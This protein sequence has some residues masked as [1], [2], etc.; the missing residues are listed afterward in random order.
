MRINIPGM[1]MI[2]IDEIIERAPRPKGRRINLT[3]KKKIKAAVKPKAK[4]K[5]K[6]RR[7]STPRT[8]DEEINLENI[9]LPEIGS[10]LPRPTR[11]DT[12]PKPKPK[13]P[14]NLEDALISRRPPVL[15]SIPGAGGIET[16]NIPGV[17][18]IQLPNVQ[19]GEVETPPGIYDDSR[20]FELPPMSGNR[21][22]NPPLGKRADGSIIYL[23]D[24]DAFDILKSQEI[25]ETQPVETQ[26]ETAST[27]Q[28][29]TGTYESSY[30]DWLESEPQKPTVR[31]ARKLP[32]GGPRYKEAQEQYRQDLANWEASKPVKDTFTAPAP[33]PSPVDTQPV[34]TLPVET[35]PTPPPAPPV[36]PFEGFVPRNIIGPSFDPKDVS[37]QKQQVADARARMTPGA[38]IQGG[39]YLTYDNPMLGNKQT[40]FGGY[41]Q[42]MPTAPLMN[43]A[44]LSSPTTYSTPAPD[45]DAQPG[46]PPPPPPVFTY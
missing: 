38:N 43:Y 25:T 9:N 13:P 41:G 16:I 12:T 31:P 11:V 20:N 35:E 44:G 18:Q 21:G 32:G 23:M 40:Q 27:A 14:V 10:I 22:I 29:P 15:G 36:N 7:I 4:P 8:F 28:T 42:P 17:G 5:R 6:P 33:A 46:G 26:P 3:P 39:G 34:E 45:P 1:E 30:I 24:D 37:Y 19:S 2:N